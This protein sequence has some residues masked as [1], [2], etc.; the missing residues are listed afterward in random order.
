MGGGFL[1]KPDCPNYK[2]TPVEQL[3]RDDHS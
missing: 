2:Q 1:Y 3:K